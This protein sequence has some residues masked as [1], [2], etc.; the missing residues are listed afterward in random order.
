[1]DLSPSLPTVWEV[2]WILDNRRTG[3]LSIQ[4]G[5][6]PVTFCQRTLNSD[7][8]KRLP[9]DMH[10]HLHNQTKSAKV[11]QCKGRITHRRLEHH[12]EMRIVVRIHRLAAIA[13]VLG[14][15]CAAE[16]LATYSVHA[17]VTHSGGVQ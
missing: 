5:E 1:M 6:L 3:L 8:V 13:Q 14:A 11:V 2:Y 10:I 9:E 12:E 15:I 17:T 4:L 16:P 7:T